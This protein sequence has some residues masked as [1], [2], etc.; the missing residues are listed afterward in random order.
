MQSTLNKL[1]HAKLSFYFIF[2]L[3]IVLV[4]LASIF[5][6][7]HLA[8]VL[9]D[10]T[11][12]PSLLWTDSIICQVNLYDHNLFSTVSYTANIMHV[13]YIQLLSDTPFQMK[14]SFVKA[15]KSHLSIS[16]GRVYNGPSL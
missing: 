16:M 3:D 15:T 5:K 10:C 13:I 9:I 11:Y 12:W 14:N 2:Y 4:L 1:K 6:F 7:N 8:Q